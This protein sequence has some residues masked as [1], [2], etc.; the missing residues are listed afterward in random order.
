[1][2]DSLLIGEVEVHLGY[3]RGLRVLL[4]KGHSLHIGGG[5]GIEFLIG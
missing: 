4:G 1:M 2:L 5:Y 3:E